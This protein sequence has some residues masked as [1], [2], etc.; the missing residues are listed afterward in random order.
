MKSGNP[1]ITPVSRRRAFTLIELLVVIAIIAILAAM[2]LPALARAKSCAQ[3]VRCNSNLRQLQFAWQV[4]ADDANGRLVPNWIMIIW[5]VYQLQDST[6]NSWVTGSA[7]HNDCLDGIQQGLLW[8]YNK[9]DGIY[10]CPADQSVWPYGTRLARRPFNIALSVAMNGGWN[11]TYGKAAREYI[12][13]KS[14]EITHP[15]AL[16]TFIDEEAKSMTSGEFVIDPEHPEHWYMIAGARD[17][18]NGANVAFADGHVTFHKWQFPSRTREGWTTPA[19]NNPDRADMA[20]ML[21]A[22]PDPNEK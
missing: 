11:N 21:A 18:G 3:S 4:Y 6:S 13:V 14:S 16:F 22:M 7:M 1:K 8:P 17:R 15:S 12:K 9:S 5:G 19:T 20:W 10:R 2:L